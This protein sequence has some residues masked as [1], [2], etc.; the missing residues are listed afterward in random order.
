L[1]CR[2]LL[3]ERN[4]PPRDKGLLGNLLRRA[5]EGRERNR[6]APRVAWLDELNSR[7]KPR[8]EIQR[9]KEHSSDMSKGAVHELA[10]PVVDISTESL[11]MSSEN[12]LSHRPTYS[13]PHPC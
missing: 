12:E 13:S 2:N 3:Y 1:R 4:M 8:R 10:L 11:R 9:G 5:H 6:P 7:A